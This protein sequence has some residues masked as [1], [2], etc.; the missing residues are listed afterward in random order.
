[1][2][3]EIMSDE[4]EQFIITGMVILIDMD[5]F[6]MSHITSTPFSTMKKLMP[7]FEVHYFNI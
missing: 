4:D 6:T 3:S 5:G 2:I 1:M 7:C